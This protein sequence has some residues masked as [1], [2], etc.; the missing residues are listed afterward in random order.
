MTVEMGSIDYEKAMEFAEAGR[1]QEALCCV[2]EHLRVEPNDAQALNDAGVILHCL[3]RS[4]EAINSLV[5]ARNLRG[6]CAEIVWNLAE[7]YL[8]EA[9]AEEAVELFDDME[10]MSLLNVDLLN[11]T[12]NIFLNQGDKTRAIEV[13]LRSL[14]LWPN[15]KIIEPMVEVIRAQRPKIAFFCGITGKKKG[16]TDISDFIS[17]RFGMRA[18][19]GHNVEQ[20]FEMM[21]WCDIAW[22]ECCTDSFVE[23]SRLPKVCKN[24]VRL[25]HF[26]AYDNWPNQPVRSPAPD[27]PKG[28]AKPN[29][30]LQRVRWENIDILI[31]VDNSFLKEALI[32]QVPDIENRTRLITIP[33]GV[34]LD[35]FKLIG[36]ERGKNLACIGPLNIKKNPMFL[37]Q[38]MQKLHYIDPEYK[39]Y[40]AGSFQS[41]MLQQYIEHMVGALGLTDVVFF[42]GWQGDVNAW[43]RDKHY[44]VSGSIGGSQDMG[45]LEGMA[46][47]LKPIIHNFPGARVIFPQEFLFNISEQFCE[48][49]LS[50]SYEPERYRRFVEENYPLKN[51]LSKISSI[52]SQL[53]AE[54]DLH[55]IED[56]RH[57]TQDFGF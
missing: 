40:F 3:G 20:M 2:E 8:A 34:N 56:S 35:K 21:K 22:F 52:F 54:I 30:R 55:R 10:R 50:N 16:L 13:L 26:E 18:F 32:N 38:C 23:A 31:T 14:Q 17:R 15:Q 1:Y 28:M 7:A 42:D 37:L 45:V 24:I 48:Q 5:Q 51:Q 46:C 53:E 36:R 25:C 9:R 39:L 41:P 11:R 44:M 47:G 49:I 4:S 19:E 29:T 57:K 27:L 33:N 6:D 12:A 43:L